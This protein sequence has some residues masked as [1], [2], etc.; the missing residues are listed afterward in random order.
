MSKNFHDDKFADISNGVVDI[1]AMVNC[2]SSVMMI[3][4]PP[5]LEY[6]LE[7]AIQGDWSAYLNM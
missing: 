5:M 1:D 4:C 6:S 7:H 2:L 3:G